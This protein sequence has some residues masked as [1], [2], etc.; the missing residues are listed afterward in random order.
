MAPIIIGVV[1]LKPWIIQLLYSEEFI[2][3]LSIT[4]WMLIG[5]YFKVAGWVFAMPML[6]YADMRAFFV[7]EVV[8]NLTFLVISSVSVRLFGSLQ[9]VGVVF[10]IMYVFYLGYVLYYVVKCYRVSV[11]IQMTLSWS[12]GLV[13][14]IGA[15]VCTWTDRN[16]YV[17]DL[18]PWLGCAILY[19]AAWVGWE[20]RK[21][22]S[23][24][25]FLNQIKV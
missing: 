10:L 12:I 8:W 3:S 20:V 18:I 13:L 17:Q 19:F 15:S 9:V 23:L 21:R 5:D 2:E 25:K 22:G 24:G 6:A 4:R 14:I 7:T 11:D 1:I 16:I